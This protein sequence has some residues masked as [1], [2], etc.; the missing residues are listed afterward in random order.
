MRTVVAFSFLAV[1]LVV[2]AAPAKAQPVDV[3]EL[4]QNPLAYDGQIITLE[5]E[6]I[7]DYGERGDEVWVQ[8]NDDPYTENP[9]P[10]GGVPAGGNQGIGLRIPVDIYDPDLWGPPGSARYRGPLVR[11][12]GRF[13]Y[14]AAEASG[15]T[16]VQVTDIELLDPAR[17]LP[18]GELG[19]PG[20]TGIALL[21]L[22]AIIY[23]A[24]R[25]RARP[26]RG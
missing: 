10:G 6:L 26:P 22:A 24:A 11:V 23:A 17:P 8:L 16:F 15:E 19:T 1:L 25:Y 3:S 18:T 4:D 12:V 7:G 2:P 21:V 9:I 14:H 5:G 20:R 13:R